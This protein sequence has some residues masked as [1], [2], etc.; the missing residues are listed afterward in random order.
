MN[1]DEAYKS[2]KTYEAYVSSE[3]KAERLTREQAFRYIK[4]AREN[5]RNQNYA[6][7]L[8]RNKHAS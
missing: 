5:Y 8:E 3:L 1:K 4:E 7:N 6:R 2:F